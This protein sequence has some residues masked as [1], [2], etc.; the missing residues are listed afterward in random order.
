MCRHCNSNSLPHRRTTAPPRYTLPPPRPAEPWPV[1]NCRCCWLLLFPSP[2]GLSDPDSAARPSVQGAI[3][4]PYSI[5]S[6]HSVAPRRRQRLLPTLL[7]TRNPPVATNCLRYRPFALLSPRASSHH[8]AAFFG[9]PSYLESTCW[10]L[11][12]SSGGSGR[13]LALDAPAKSQLKA[14]T[15]A[16]DIML[17]CLCHSGASTLYQ[18]PTTVQRHVFRQWSPA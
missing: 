15:T 5:M 7:D 16:H 4:F 8:Q 18:S 6:C 2:P 11:C 13:V 1:S 17:T 12:R 9:P 10:N 14:I 3:S